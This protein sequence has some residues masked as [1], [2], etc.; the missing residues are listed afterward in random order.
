MSPFYKGAIELF[1][2]YGLC[3]LEKSGGS[4]PPPYGLCGLEKKSGGSKPAA[5]LFCV[6]NYAF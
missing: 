2:P 1:P 3:G 4:K 6:L 5:I